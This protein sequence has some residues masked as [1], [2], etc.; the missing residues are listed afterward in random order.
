MSLNEIT[1]QGDSQH[2]NQTVNDK[3]K[4]EFFKNLS[5]SQ[6]FSN[7]EIKEIMFQ[8]SSCQKADKM[9]EEILKS[10]EGTNNEVN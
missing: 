3:I 4:S 2:N 7:N 8:I 9:A 1:K 6:K 5:E 10:I